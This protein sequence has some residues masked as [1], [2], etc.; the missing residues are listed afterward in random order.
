[1]TW[2]WTPHVRGGSTVFLLLYTLSHL[3]L[4]FSRPIRSTTQ[5]APPRC[6]RPSPLLLHHGVATSRPLL[7]S[8]LHPLSPRHPCFPRIEKLAGRGLASARSQPRARAPPA[9][10]SGLWALARGLLSWTWI[11]GLNRRRGRTRVGV[12]GGGATG[13]RP[14]AAHLRPLSLLAPAAIGEEPP[15]STVATGELWIRLSTTPPP[16]PGGGRGPPSFSLLPRAPPH[17]A[18]HLPGCDYR[19][20]RCRWALLLRRDRVGE[21]N[22]LAP[23]RRRGTSSIGW[24][25]LTMHRAAA[26][27]CPRADHW[28]ETPRPS[29]PLP[30]PRGLRVDV[31]I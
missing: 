27:T 4:P 7:T 21:Q 20:Q 10:V 19:R 1:M 12:G 29:P 8:E 24:R 11:H 9:G 15:R 23:L 2:Q 14:P 6:R 3:P 28:G 16:G 30:P 26:R 18:R 5:S 13:P 22:P 25:S 31:D 17:R